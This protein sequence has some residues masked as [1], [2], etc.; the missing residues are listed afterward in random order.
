VAAERDGWILVAARWP[1][2]IREI[3]PSK[4]AELEDPQMVRFYRLASE[5]LETDPADDSRL[6]EVADIMVGMAERAYAA[7]EGNSGKGTHD[8]LPFD[9][10]DA[11][12]VETDPRAQ[13]LLDLLRERGW[14]SWTR[15]E[16]TRIER[17]GDPRLSTMQ[18][19]AQLPVHRRGNAKD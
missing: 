2:S 3:M 6:R 19:V 17:P 1:D 15:M 13:L 18:R 5:L 11:L 4:F 8:E 7:S 16:W 12:A 9:L 14:G 10:L